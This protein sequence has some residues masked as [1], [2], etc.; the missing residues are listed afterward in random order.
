MCRKGFKAPSTHRDHMYLH[1]KKQFICIKC[2]KV[3]CYPSVFQAHMISHHKSKMYHCFAA[4]CRSEYKYK[5]DLLRH[6]KWHEPVLHCCEECDYSTSE[7]RLLKQHMVQ[8]SNKKAYRC[9]ECGKKYKH[10]NSLN[11]HRE[12]CRQ[13]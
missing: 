9:G 2:N 10:Y 12:E 13:H 11:R 5:Q 1:R 7:K 8:H 6:V 3:F 4:R